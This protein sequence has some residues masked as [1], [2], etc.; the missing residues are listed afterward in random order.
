DL[1]K[2]N[3]VLQKDTETPPCV[4]E[5]IGGLNKLRAYDMEPGQTV[6][7]PMSTGKK[8]AVVRVDAREYDKI[9]T[10]LG[11]F[12]TLKYEVHMFNDVL[13]KKKARMYLWLT[14]DE[15]KLPVQ[16]QVRLQFLIGTITLQLEKEERA[17]GASAGASN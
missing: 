3:I 2:N 5:Y 7:I 1:L 16:I 6:N 17:T 4:H 9:T 8:F 10:P 13:L 14:N 11:K 12:D 15:R